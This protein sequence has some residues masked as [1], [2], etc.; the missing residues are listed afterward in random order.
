MYVYIKI[1]IK[2][3]VVAKTKLFEEELQERANIFKTLSHPARLQII[4]FLIQTRKC[5][6]GDI[7]DIFPLNRTTLNQH[8]KELKDS[9]L[10]TTHIKGSKMIHC[11]D[12]NK[13]EETRNILSAFLNEINLPKD[14]CCD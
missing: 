14:F 4:Q 9:G 13:I 7:S 5:L 12:I 2:N 1:K 3:M 11:L 10:I 8:L 6:S